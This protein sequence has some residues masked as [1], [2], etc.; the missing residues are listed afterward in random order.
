LRI[1]LEGAATGDELSNSND[2]LEGD[3]RGEQKAGGTGGRTSTRQKGS[4]AGCGK[5]C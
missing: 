4:R 5:P 3:E 1:L 2:L